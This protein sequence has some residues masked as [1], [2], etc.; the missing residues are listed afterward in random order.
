MPPFTEVGLVDGHDA[1]QPRAG[2]G[3][4]FLLEH[5]QLLGVVLVTS[6]LI[7]CVSP[8]RCRAPP[9]RRY[10][11]VELVGVQPVAEHERQADTDHDQDRGSGRAALPELAGVLVAL[12]SAHTGAGQ[13]A[14]TSHGVMYL[15][16]V[17]QSERRVDIGDH[18]ATLRIEAADPSSG[19]QADV[20]VC[21][22]PRHGRGIAS[23]DALR[24]VV[25]EQWTGDRSSCVAVQGRVLWADSTLAGSLWPDCDTVR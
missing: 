7:E 2:I 25:S 15:P 23:Q 13:R 12:V 6:I 11:G 4:L 9:C 18:P 5:D 22:G 8:G 20:R 10:Y 3:S 16:A 19:M 21:G 17:V 1:L 24:R 14:T